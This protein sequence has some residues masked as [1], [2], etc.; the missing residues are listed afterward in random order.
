MAR[1]AEA[2]RRRA[3]KRNITE[4]DQRRSDSQEMKRQSEKNRI[5]QENRDKKNVVGNS[6]GSS[7]GASANSVKQTRNPHST[8]ALAGPASSINTNTN[9]TP[10][11][12]TTFFLSRFSC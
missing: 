2:I 9:T 1:S 8:K 6:G 10:V 11:L 5:Q 12:T 4:Q 3:E 7:S